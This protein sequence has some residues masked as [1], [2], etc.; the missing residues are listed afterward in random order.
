MPVILA[1][2]EAEIRNIL[3]WS[4][5]GQIVLKTY[6]ENTQHTHKKGGWQ[7]DSSGTCLASMKPWVQT[8]VPPK[9]NKK[10][11]V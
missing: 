6:L 8:L 11:N 3:V 7:S 1:S 9:L 5:P 10:I 4:Q 2:L